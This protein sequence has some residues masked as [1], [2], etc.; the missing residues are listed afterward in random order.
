[1]ST[2]TTLPKLTCSHCGKK[3]R[4]KNI[5]PSGTSFRCPGCQGQIIYTTDSNLGS[6][7]Y[8]LV[9]ETLP[10]SIPTP[11]QPS[12]THS[13]PR[14]RNQSR[15]TRISLRSSRA[16]FG[17]VLGL[18]LGLSGLILGLTVGRSKD[19]PPKDPPKPIALAHPVQKVAPELPSEAG[20]TKNPRETDCQWLGGIGRGRQVQWFETSQR[21]RRIRQ[22]FRCCLQPQGRG[23][24]SVV[25]R[26]PGSC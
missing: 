20:P 14:P 4:F 17:L 26:R 21:G 12:E 9:S 25:Y 3:I 6:S 16:I 2:T 1:M 23:L 11:I 8:D 18:I 13:A 24:P 7:T 19:V 5:P 10:P 15:P 22:L